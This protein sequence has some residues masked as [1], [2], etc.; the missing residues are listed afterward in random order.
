ME[1]NMSCRNRFVL[2]DCRISRA[3]DPFHDKKKRRNLNKIV[4]KKNLINN[5]IYDENATRVPFENICRDH[6]KKSYCVIKNEISISF[7]LRRKI[8][9]E[10]DRGLKQKWGWVNICLSVINPS[11][12]ILNYNSDIIKQHWSYETCF[13]GEIHQICHFKKEQGDCWINFAGRWV[14]SI[15]LTW[16][17]QNPP[18]RSWCLGM[19]ISLD[20]PC[21]NI[22]DMTQ[23]NKIWSEC[24]MIYNTV[25]NSSLKMTHK[26]RGVWQNWPLIS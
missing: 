2:F 3:K 17:M 21:T 12:S 14:H 4:N 13:L 16:S 26:P 18:R 20:W 7:E 8:V 19:D 1:S 24:V 11:E 15:L 9:T 23:I 10:M 25:I 6:L 22:G 5:C